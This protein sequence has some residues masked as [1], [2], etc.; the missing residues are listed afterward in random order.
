[1]SGYSLDT[2]ISQFLLHYTITPHTNT[3]K[4]SNGRCYSEGGQDL[5]HPNVRARVI[6]SQEDQRRTA[7]YVEETVSPRGRCTLI[8]FATGSSGCQIECCWL[9]GCAP[10]IILVSLQFSIL[11]KSGFIVRKN[12][13]NVR[14]FLCI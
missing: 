1:M 3:G 6:R 2:N 12:L 5:L 4:P 10:E 14:I 7:L 9:E 13:S 8:F 11:K